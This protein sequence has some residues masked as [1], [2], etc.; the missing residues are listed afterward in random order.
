MDW[1]FVSPL[2]NSDDKP[3][4]RWRW[5]FMETKLN[6]ATGQSPDPTRLVYKSNFR[7]LVLLWGHGKKQAPTRN[8]PARSGSRTA[9]LQDWMKIAFCCLS[10]PVCGTNC[11]ISRFYTMNSQHMED[12]MLQH[13]HQQTSQHR[14][15]PTPR[16]AHSEAKTG[17]SS[18]QGQKGH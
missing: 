1:T 7:E 5:A 18:Y 11:G 9:G 8:S 4:M 16:S 10:S 12:L 13:Q 17:G 3:L 6:E 14:S 15:L 2:Q